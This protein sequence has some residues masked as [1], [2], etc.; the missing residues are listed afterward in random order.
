MANKSVLIFGATGYIGASFLSRLAE[1]YLH[2]PA[3]PYTVTAS[4]RSLEKARKLKGL[5]P[6]VKTTE[7]T[8]DDGAELEKEV[9][10]YDMVIQLVSNRRSHERA[11]QHIVL[12]TCPG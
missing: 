6:N 12:T 5:L 3:T 9:E 1:K 8:L 2:S 10:K 7:I 11:F 4:T